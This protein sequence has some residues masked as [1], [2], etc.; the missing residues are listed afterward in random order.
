MFETHCCSS[1]FLGLVALTIEANERLNIVE[2]PTAKWF[3]FNIFFL[4][5]CNLKI[6]FINVQSM[7]Q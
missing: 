4:Y 1:N 6:M 3:S 2:V 5:V 7:Q